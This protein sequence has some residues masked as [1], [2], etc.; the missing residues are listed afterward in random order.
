MASSHEHTV[1]A[2]DEDI[3][4][5]RALIAQ[6]GGLAEQ[7]IRDAISALHPGDSASPAVGARTRRSTSSRPR[8]SA[9]WSS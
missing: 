2:F 9:R 1:K 7:A 8:S 6:M 5:L 4:Q 3:G